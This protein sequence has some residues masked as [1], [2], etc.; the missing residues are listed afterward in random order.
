MDGLG[1][2]VTTGNMRRPRIWKAGQVVEELGTTHLFGLSG[3]W[4]ADRAQ[5]RGLD[6]FLGRAAGP[7]QP[8]SRTCLP[9]QQRHPGLPV[10]HAGDQKHQVPRPQEL[11]ESGPPPAR[12]G[13]SLLL[14]GLPEQTT[15]PRP[16]RRWLHL[17]RCGS[18]LSSPS[19]P[20][21]PKH[22]LTCHLHIALVLQAN[23]LN[24]LH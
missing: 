19:S 11:G 5:S 13:P 20:L 21:P 1:G 22:T 18:R 10:W 12:A 16:L 6:P 4:E 8:P 15:C 17:L 3:P 23:P 14:L 9:G 2:R 7:G 24:L